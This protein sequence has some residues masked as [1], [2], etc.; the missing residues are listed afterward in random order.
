MIT[1]IE[2]LAIFAILFVVIPTTYYISEIKGLPKWL[3]Y[4]PFSCWLCCTFWSLLVIYVTLG[5]ALNS[6]IIGVGGSILAI[7]NAIAMK[8]DQKDKT[9]NI[10]EYDTRT[11]FINREV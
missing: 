1:I 2:V 7:L 6:Y 11:S 9:I 4:K 8:I 3:N 5:F 10:E